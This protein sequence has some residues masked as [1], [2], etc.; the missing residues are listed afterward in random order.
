MFQNGAIFMNILR[1]SVGFGAFIF[2]IFFIPSSMNVLAKVTSLDPV[3]QFE[4][5]LKIDEKEYKIINDSSVSMQPQSQYGIRKIGYGKEKIVSIVRSSSGTYASDAMIS[6]NIRYPGI[7]VKQIR[8]EQPENAIIYLLENGW[9][10]TPMVNANS[11][12]VLNKAR[13]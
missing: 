4:Q 2:T 11:F 8:S 5:L 9:I 10:A 1:N 13:P 7:I 3:P 12:I 6:R